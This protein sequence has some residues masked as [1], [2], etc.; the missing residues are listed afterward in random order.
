MPDGRG[1]TT[2]TLRKLSC[3]SRQKASF[4]KRRTTPG[5]STL[6]RSRFNFLAFGVQTGRAGAQVEFVGVVADV[7]EIV[8]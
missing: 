7:A 5:G 4:S 6:V 2:R 3:G 1:H 8:P